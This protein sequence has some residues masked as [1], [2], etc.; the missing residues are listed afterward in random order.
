MIWRMWGHFVHRSSSGCSSA[1]GELAEV[2]KSLLI[3]RDNLIGK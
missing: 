2:R 3:R 1:S